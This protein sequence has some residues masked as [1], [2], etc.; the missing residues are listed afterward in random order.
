MEG[1][2]DDAEMVCTALKIAT[3]RYDEVVEDLR[4]QQHEK[5]CRIRTCRVWL[6]IKLD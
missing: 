3:R 1:V 2:L 6:I 5:A 4:Q